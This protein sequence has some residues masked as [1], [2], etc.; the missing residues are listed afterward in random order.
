VCEIHVTENQKIEWKN[1]VEE[2]K[3]KKNRMSLQNEEEVNLAKAGR[4]C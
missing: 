2:T 1:S 4:W 3:E